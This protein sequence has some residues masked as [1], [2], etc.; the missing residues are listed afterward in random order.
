MQ[1]YDTVLLRWTNS[2]HVIP[3]ALLTAS[4]GAM[5]EL[6]KTAFKTALGIS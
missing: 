1:V 4:V 5:T 3:A 6:E 2:E